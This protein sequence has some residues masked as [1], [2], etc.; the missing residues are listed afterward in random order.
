MQPFNVGDFV[1]YEINAGRALKVS[2]VRFDG[3]RWWLAFEGYHRR[4]WSLSS[5]FRLA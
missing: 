5:L 1:V 4:F 2:A 3:P